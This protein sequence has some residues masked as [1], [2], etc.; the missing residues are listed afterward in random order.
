MAILFASFIAGA[1][2]AF[3]P[4]TLPF[5][6][7]IVAGTAP[8]A[9]NENKN[10]SYRRIFFVIIGLTSSIFVFSLLL[11]S[12]TA[13]IAI[14]SQAWST[15]SAV[16]VIGLGIVLVA[17]E[18]WEKLLMKLNLGA[19]AQTRLSALSSMHSDK[20]AF[21]TGAALGPVFNSCSPTYA[22]IIAILLPN[23]IG[24]GTFAL[25]LYCLGLAAA[26]LA[27]SL[28]SSTAI[29]SVARTGKIVDRVKKIIGWALIV[30]GIVILFGLDKKL[31]TSLLDAGIYQP[32]ESIERAIT[33]LR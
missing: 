6:P 17:P 31:Q 25:L 2:T 12:T 3:A 29:R 22:L 1:L 28:I 16:I 11:K 19:S 9:A 18:L 4:C 27:I 7:L 21:L 14:P 32:L 15:L 13:L 24:F 8:A 5:L 10:V 26:L 20:G 23:S 30:V 33:N